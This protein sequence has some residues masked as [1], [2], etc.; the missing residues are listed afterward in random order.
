MP[1]VVSHDMVM[2]E[3]V[4]GFEE[5]VTATEA[6]LTKETKMLSH[7]TAPDVAIA[8]KA[9]MTDDDAAKRDDVG[10]EGDAGS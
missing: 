7:R 2:G 9:V 5:R 3:H 10:K 1:P 4:V 6:A 8:K